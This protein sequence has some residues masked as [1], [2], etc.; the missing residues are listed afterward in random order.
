MKLHIMLMKAPYGL[1]R[2]SGLGCI[3]FTLLNRDVAIYAQY[4]GFACVP[5]IPLIPS[6]DFGTTDALTAKLSTFQ[7]S[8]DSILR[9]QSRSDVYGHSR[10]TRLQM[11]ENARCRQ[12]R[13]DIL[14]YVGSLN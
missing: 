1:H 9:R 4:L 10:Q 12:E 3:A 11:R 14:L 6:E 13:M 5:N 2:P 7:I 8:N